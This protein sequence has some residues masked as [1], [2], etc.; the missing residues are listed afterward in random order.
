M[1]QSNLRQRLGV[2]IL[3]ATLASTGVAQAGDLPSAADAPAASHE[4]AMAEARKQFQ[5]GVNLLDDPDGA[6]YEEAYSAFRK[7]YDLSQSTKV[8]GNMA[9]CAMHLERDGEA[10]DAYTKY[11]SDTLDVPERERA[12][13]QKD[14]ATLT[15]TVARLRVVV[16]RP[17]TQLILVD[18]RVQTRGP[19]VENTYSFTGDELTIRLRPGRHTLK[20]K[21]DGE[22]SL[23]ME[24]TIEPASQVAQEVR[25]AP[26]AAE[27]T[28]MVVRPAPSIAGPVV[29]GITGLL[30]IGAGVA[31]GLMA[32]SKT[33]DIQ[34]R[35]PNDL[36]PQDYDLAAA[37]SSAKTLGTVADATLIGGGAM[38]GGALLWYVLLPKGGAVNAGAAGAP[39]VKTSAMCTSA[40]CNLQLQ[41]GF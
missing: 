14:L 15:S 23:P 8:L 27:P 17:G 18:T 28:P 33:N 31:T 10:I 16:K 2:S 7:A 34:S 25:F 9:F 12:Q 35:C 20:V 38:L 19:S 4:K 36:C 26:K 5:A 39:R 21:A 22:E 37:R 13:I 32:R 6:K 30:G 41:G 29:F 40:G 3:L 11:L 24:L 1:A